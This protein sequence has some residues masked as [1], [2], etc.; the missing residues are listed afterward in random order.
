MIKLLLTKLFTLF[1]FASSVCLGRDCRLPDKGNCTA[2]TD[3]AQLTTGHISPAPKRLMNVS[4]SKANMV[5]YDL[6]SKRL[7][8]EFFDEY[9]YEQ[10]R[11]ETGNYSF[12][13]T[14][15]EGNLISR[16]FS[17]N[18]DS[19]PFS[20]QAVI[21][22]DDRELV[23]EPDRWPYACTALVETIF[24]SQAGYDKKT[25]Y[26]TGFLEGPNLLVTAAHCVYANPNSDNAYDPNPRF[27]DVIN[28]YAGIHSKYQVGMD[29]RYRASAKI[30]NI[31]KKYKNTPSQKWDWCALELDRN[32]GDQIGY[33]G[34][35]GNWFSAGASVFSYGYPKNLLFGM[36]EAKGKMNSLSNGIYMTDLDSNNGQSGSPIFMRSSDGESYVC[37]IL[38]HEQ[39][40]AGTCGSCFTD[41]IYNY[42]DSFVTEKNNRISLSVNSKSGL[43]WSI[44]ITNSGPKALAVSYCINMCF[45]DDAKYWKNLKNGDIR[46][47]QVNA[48]AYVNVGI[49]V[50]FLADAIATSYIEHNTRFVT[51]AN[52]LNSNGTLSEHHYW[53]D[54]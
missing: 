47:V 31:E 54:L 21:G 10:R 35:I 51:Y 53:F 38:T 24:Y 18:G 49:S 40:S 23:D 36:Y 28:V 41:F 15:G 45:L 20:L 27:P 34:K 1:L 5:N 32:L 33:Y 7:S 12:A 8:Y 17:P 22:S 52:N 3:V 14:S 30:I 6:E 44:R 9:S 39:A 46:T 50:N 42:L 37:G 43:R 16:P 29:Y 13:S 48:G 25:R 11:H 19:E 26:G 4:E 2:E